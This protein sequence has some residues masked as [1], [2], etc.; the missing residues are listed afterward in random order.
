MPI[1]RLPEKTIN[2]IAAGEVIERPAS[3]VKELVENSLDAGADQIDVQLRDGGKSLIR[4]RDNGA[5]MSPQDITLALERHATSKLT[6]G[7]LLFISTLGFR[8]EALPSIAA[9][10]RLEITSR[11]AKADSAWQVGV[12]AGLSLPPKPA[13]GP[14][15]TVV[16][17]R[18]LFYATPARLKFL[19]SDRAETSAVVDV[20]QRLA[21]AYPGVNFTLHDGKRDRLRLKNMQTDLLTRRLERLGAIMGRD[22]AENALTVEAEREGMRL[23]G[24]TGLPTLNRGNAMMQF[25][26]VNARP[27]KDRQLI[28]AVRA[29]YQDFL[30]RDRHPM[31]AL[32]LEV[33]PRFVDVNVHPAK[34]EVRFRDA[35]QVRGLLI[36]ALKQ[37]LAEAGH[38]A[39]TTV[40]KSALGAMRPN[41]GPA[42]LSFTR[43]SGRSGYAPSGGSLSQRIANQ[44]YHAPVQTGSAPQAGLE[45]SLQQPP[46]PDLTDYP[47]QVSPVETIHAFPPA[48]Q[49]MPDMVNTPEM[50]ESATEDSL[51]SAASATE[52]AMDFPLGA[53]RAQLHATY[54]VSQTRDGIILVDQHAAHERLVYEAMKQA[55][56]EGNIARQ[57]LLLPEIVE[58]PEDDVANLLSVAPDLEKLGLVLES[59]GISAVIVREMP[60][61]LGD[62]DIQGL[63]KDLVD[64]VREMGAALSLKEKIEA[65]CS[66]MACHGSV[67]AGRRLNQQEMNALLRQMEATPHSG[68]CNHGRPT[69][70]EL[71]RADIERLFGRR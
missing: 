1:R 62:A 58:M 35:G 13:S 4:V 34:T 43:A 47:S 27:V 29:A 17:V 19:R 30:A 32:F 48:A 51:A 28:G 71:K 14:V 21:M 25:M 41:Y 10:S 22:F 67:R 59:F 38:R 12:D 18:D 68:Q 56:A 46:P 3:A 53:A 50:A 16:E 23:T 44:A 2:R 54:I 66:T 20:L 39:A 6:D 69:Y 5:G 24:F 26:F 7:D 37:S 63:V 33:A 36:G 52:S 42:Q 57:A 40:A 31:L 11:T 8:G 9:V 61:I 55:L 70:V 60:V 49:V 65:V 45:N 64:E 15:G